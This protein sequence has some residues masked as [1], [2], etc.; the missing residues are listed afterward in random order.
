MLSDYLRISLLTVLC[1]VEVVATGIMMPQALKLK[2][3]PSA[4]N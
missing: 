1:H 3:V 2:K 4:I